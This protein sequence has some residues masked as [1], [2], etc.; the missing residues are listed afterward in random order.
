MIDIM[1][2]FEERLSEVEAFIRLIALVEQAAQTGNPRI[3]GREGEGG[4][5]EPLQQQILCGSVFLHLYSLV[6]ATIS[7]CIAAVEEVSCRASSPWHLSVRL[8]KEWVRSTAGTHKQL[9]PEHRLNQAFGMCDHLVGMLPTEGPRTRFRIEADSGG[10]WDDELIY[11]TMERL[12][13]AFLVPEAIQAPVKREYRDGRG[14][15]QAIKKLRNKLAHGEMSFADCGQGL[16]VGALKDLKQITV[17]YLREVIRCFIQYITQHQY[18]NPEPT[19]A[20][21]AA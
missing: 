6:E 21:G 8:R 9:T 4:L 10:N 17:N 2:D 1:S 19:R 11:K 13:V 14:P 18:L 7:R 20:E 12:G 15:L 5:I 16:T 3:V